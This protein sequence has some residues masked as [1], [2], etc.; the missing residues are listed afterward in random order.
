VA[1]EQE[2]ACVQ[3]EDSQ[4]EW[5]AVAVE[6]LGAVGAEHAGADDDRVEGEPAV[7]QL[8][9][10]FGPLVAHVPAQHVVGERGLLHGDPLRGVG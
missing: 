7:G 4:A 3:D 6:L 5:C 10:D 1:G 2:R 8:G 9:L